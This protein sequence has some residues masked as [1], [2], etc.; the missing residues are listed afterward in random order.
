L[1]EEDDKKLAERERKCRNG[2]VLCG[3]CKTILAERVNKFLAEHQKKRE[4]A[5]N[6]VHKFNV[7]R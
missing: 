5:K 3:E 1:F 2:E 7:K 4:K 6:I